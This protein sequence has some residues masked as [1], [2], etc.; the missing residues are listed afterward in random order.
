MARGGRGRSSRHC[1]WGAG[2]QRACSCWTW[3]WRGSPS[4]HLTELPP[5][6]LWVCLTLTHMH[7]APA[8][9]ALT[10]G[11]RHGIVRGAS[12]SPCWGS[13]L[14]RSLPMAGLSCQPPL[15]DPWAFCMAVVRDRGISLF[16]D[17]GHSGSLLPG[18]GLTERLSPVHGGPLLPAPQA[19]LPRGFFL[20]PTLVSPLHSR[21]QALHLGVHRFCR[22]CLSWSSVASFFHVIW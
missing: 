16:G 12:S 14:I 6:A 13:F 22:K 18:L 20:R 1:T 2:P 8:F 9:P 21:V 4:F 10:L 7:P 19:V 11:G 3:L 5:V 15:G 17:A